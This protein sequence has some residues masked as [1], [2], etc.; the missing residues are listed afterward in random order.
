[1]KTVL[2]GAAGT[3]TAFG[4]ITALRRY[5]AN[6]VR[7]VASDV[8]PPH[9][10]T[11]SILSDH[12]E[13]VPY[14]NTAAFRKALVR[15]IH[16]HQADYYL[17]LLPEEVVAALEL[18]SSSQLPKSL[19]ILSA[20]RQS[21]L[22][23]TD[24]LAVANWLET[25][26]FPFPRTADCRSPFSETAYLLKPR[27]G[28]GSRGT[29]IIQAPDLEPMVATLEGE[30]I[31]QEICAGP[32]ITVD[33]FYAP[34][35]DEYHIVCRERLEVKTGV[36][37]KARLFYDAGI[38]EITHRLAQHLPLNGTFCYQLMQKQG[39]WVIIDINPRPGAGTAMCVPSGNDFHA[40]NFAQ[41]FGESFRSFFQPLKHD[42]FVTRQ[43]SE[44][45]TGS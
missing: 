3:G 19:V 1:M 10:V 16:N 7:I 2:I 45:L 42:L 15:I 17:P 41:A 35:A 40:A 4:A 13:Q 12:Y 6:R 44:F 5:W 20:A 25:H 31:I 8:N 23:V 43:Y 27:H 9:L 11:A 24:K 30:W 34:E 14:A 26:Q 39:N 37:T 36:S 21:A 22:P 38:A 32:E 18:Q 28:S 29:S 33:G